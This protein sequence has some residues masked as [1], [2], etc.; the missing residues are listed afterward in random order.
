LKG[1]PKLQEKYSIDRTKE[2]AMMIRTW[3]LRFTKGLHAHTLLFATLALAG[4]LASAANF[5]VICPG[6]GPGAYPSITAA[7]DAIT[8]NAGPNSIT[9]GGV[10]T[11]NVT[12]R[13]QNDLNILA[14][15]GTVITNAANPAQITV[16][17]FGS[18][19]VAFFGLTIQGGNPG[20]FV[21]MG[22]GD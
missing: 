18:H 22:A 9:V 4:G 20:L 5:N 12:I 3:S 6:G 13:N 14:A 21:T 7:L 1:T 8:N 17:L 11:E 10:C 16:Q 15:P 19:L 2:T